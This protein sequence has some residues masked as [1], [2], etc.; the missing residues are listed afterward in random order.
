MDG[1]SGLNVSTDV[2]PV[3]STL[4]VNYTPGSSNDTLL[5]LSMGTL[6]HSVIIANSEA[7]ANP[8]IAIRLFD[9]STTAGSVK[10]DNF[11]VIPEPSTYVML[12]LGF[13]LLLVLRR[14]RISA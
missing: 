13:V 14:R 2:S 9:P 5:S 4:T 3:F 7:I 11:S 6:N 1:S 12:L 8:R 10:F